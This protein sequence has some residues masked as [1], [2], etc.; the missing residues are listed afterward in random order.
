MLRALVLTLSVGLSMF[1]ATTQAARSEEAKK[2]YLFV[3]TAGEGRV[4]GSVLTMSRLGPA[5]VYFADRPDRDVGYVTYREFLDAWKRAA[6][7]FASDPPNASLVYRDGGK[8]VVVVLELMEP[9]LLD[10][11]LSYKVRPLKG[12]LP[13]QFGPVSL[14]IDAGGLMQLVAYGAQGTAASPKK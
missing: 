13:T 10:G 7:S 14:F 1:V 5:V 9:S 4:N 6:N 12:N 8:Q 3:Q 2:Q 11:A